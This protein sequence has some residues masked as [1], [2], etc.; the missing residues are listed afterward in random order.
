MM[1]GKYIKYI[2]FMIASLIIMTSCARRKDYKPEGLK[3][4]VE[5]IKIEN[6]FIDEIEMSYNYR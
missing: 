6:S 5:E 4:L 1:R 3:Q 2:L